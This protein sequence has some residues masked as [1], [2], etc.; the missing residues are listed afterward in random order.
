MTPRSDSGQTHECGE[1]PAASGEEQGGLTGAAGLP[2]SSIIAIDPGPHE[3]ALLV[4]TPESKR[5]GHRVIDLNE[6]ILQWLRLD[7]MMAAERGDVL[8]IEMV[9]SFGMPVGAEVFAT[10]VWI[11]RFY[12]AARP[13]RVELITRMKVKHRL[14]HNARAKDANIRQALIDE[15]GPVGT[16]GER[17]PTYGIT[18]HLWSALGVAVTAASILELDDPNDIALIRASRELDARGWK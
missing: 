12:E 7:A 10:V 4:Y 6:R 18:T 17:G 3:S 5:I 9:S 11:G 8:A 16:T 2:C 13:M 15:V 1:R 14:C